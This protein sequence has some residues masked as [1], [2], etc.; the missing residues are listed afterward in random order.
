MRK[1]AAQWNE[2]NESG[3]GRMKGEVLFDCYYWK[4]NLKNDAC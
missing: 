1:N 3:E 4:D 2:A